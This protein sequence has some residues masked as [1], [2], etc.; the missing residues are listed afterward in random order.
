MIHATRQPAAGSGLVLASL[1]SLL[2][3]LAAC[4]GGEPAADRPRV[5]CT[6]GM[7]TDLAARIGGD[8]LQVDGLMGP[9]VDPHLYK[10]SAGDLH[11]LSRADLVLSNGLHLEARLGEVLANLREARAVALCEGLEGVDLL[12][13]AGGGD[14]PD[15]HLWFDVAAWSRVARRIGEEL[16]RL[17]PPG[18]ASH[19]ERAARLAEGLDSLD[20][21]IR[22]RT[23]A[24]PPE[25]RVLVTAHDAF[26]YFGRAYGFEVRGLQ[27]I[28]TV[29]EAGARD[30]QELAA[31]LAERRIPAIFVESSVPRR[32]LE[33][34]RE[35][36]Q[37]AGHEVAIG[38]ELYSDALGSAGTP[39]AT[40]EGMVAHNV[41]T[42][43]QALAVPK[44]AP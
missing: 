1:L 22:A 29:A 10:A 25:R 38:G 28:S 9:G 18:A 31:F 24:L 3:L 43:L 2:L 34:V 12:V 6:T 23:A 32:T 20:A 4:V 41:D 35:A 36:A 26:Q 37:A 14:L 27:G 42:I 11:L 15:P 30:V 5:V 17:D 19:R 44:E 33:A 40:Y 13:A 8:R 16:A 39:A 21:A 7:I